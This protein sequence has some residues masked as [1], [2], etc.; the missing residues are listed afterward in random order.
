M[1]RGR[2]LAFAPAALIVVITAITFW[3]GLR[4]EFLNWD[5]G[6]LFTKNPDYRG[7]GPAQLRWMFT[8]I[9]A[10]HYMPLTWLTLGFNYVLGGMD[11]W[12]YHLFALI[13]HATNAV[14]FYL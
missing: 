12:G 2:L 7:L 9:L 4:G 10:G 8:T 6:F 1:R 11:P 3:P 13:L 5:D 14:L